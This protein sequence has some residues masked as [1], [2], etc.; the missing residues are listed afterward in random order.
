MRVDSGFRPLLEGFD[1]AALERDGAVIYGLFPDFRIGYLNDAYVRFAA[2]NGGERVLVDWELGAD[3]LAAVH[4]KI[5]DFYADAFRRVLADGQPWEQTY[6]CHSP[7]RYRTYR[8]RVLPLPGGRGLL[9]VHSNVADLPYP[10]VSRS[11]TVDDVRYR[12]E[13]GR[14]TLCA[15]CRRVRRVAPP[16]GWEWVASFVESTPANAA[17]SL[18]GVC[19]DYYYP[20][21]TGP[22][23]LP[24]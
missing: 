8:M 2:E 20:E 19:A 16:V 18:C 4:G 3:A 6:H 1:L 5:R 11:V 13:A 10:R 17:S 21:V 9:V 22:V 24:P 14:V 15:H 12:D 7:D 23:P